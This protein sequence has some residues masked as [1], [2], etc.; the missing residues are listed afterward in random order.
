MKQNRRKFIK[1][2]G[3]VALAFGAGAVVGSAA[4]PTDWARGIIGANSG[5]GCTYS[6]FLAPS[7]A[8]YCEF[9]CPPGQACQGWCKNISSENGVTQQMNGNTKE[10]ACPL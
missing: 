9:A 10:V 8:Y 1:T 2:T 6:I 4:G 3:G 7:G 5:S